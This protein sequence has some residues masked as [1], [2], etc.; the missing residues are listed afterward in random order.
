MTQS[1]DAA[2]RNALPPPDVSGTDG[3]WECS[4]E[5]TRERQKRLFFE[6]TPAERLRWLV[7]IQRI[8]HASGALPR[9]RSDP[10]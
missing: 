8:A 1:D 2:K 6:A 5:A 3:D 7:E 9:R 10:A 4:W